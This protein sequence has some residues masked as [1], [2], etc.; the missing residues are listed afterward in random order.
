M[1]ALFRSE[2]LEDPHR[3]GLGSIR[4]IRPVSFAL[5]TGLTVIMVMAVVAFLVLGEYTR[6]ARVSGFLVPDRGVIRLVAPQAATVLESHAAEG[7]VVKQGD[8]LFVLAVDQAALTGETQAAV[9]DSLAA[10]ERSLRGAVRQQQQLEQ[11]RVLALDRQIE[12]MR[13]E[14]VQ[15]DAEAQLQRQRLTLAQQAQSRLESLRLENFVSA[16]QVHTKTEEVLA[17][18]AQV[19]GLERQRTV[20]Q[21]EID[22]LQAQRRELPL[23]AQAVQGEIERDLAALSQQAAQTETGRRFVLRAP[24]DG[25]VTAVLAEAGHSVNAASALAS[26]LPASAS[27]QAHLYAPS[28]AVGFVRPEQVVLLRYQA[29]PYQKFGHQPGRV[30]QV[31]RSPLQA[32]ELAGLSWSGAGGG[33]G[34]V[35]SAVASE[36][37]YRITVALERQSVSAYGQA[38][39]LAP[40]MQMD[41]DVLLDR[42]RLIEWLFEP[43]LGVAGRV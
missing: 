23:Q 20:H 13:R 7:R 38:Q 3:H 41:A 40:G 9:K 21:R 25:T 16:A 12:Q 8:V 43:V 30:L 10:R 29:F 15:L 17:I 5:L 19:Q 39:P 26:L 37:L 24:Q 33:A 35:S 28:S 34:V 27:L 42:R 1:A 31:S 4:L 6:K 18:R 11:S 22:Q 2:V 32:S 36:P 14:L